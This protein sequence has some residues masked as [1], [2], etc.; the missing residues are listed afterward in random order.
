MSQSTRIPYAHTSPFAKKAISKR[1]AH[2]K[3][4]LNN[5]T[6]QKVLLFT[7]ILGLLLV[8]ANLD[9]IM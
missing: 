7:T 4:L 8:A 2:I 6:V 5:E 3:S 9:N 1:M